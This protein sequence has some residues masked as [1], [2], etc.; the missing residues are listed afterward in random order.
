[1]V[2]TQWL[3]TDM[4][5][6]TLTVLR[7]PKRSPSATFAARQMDPRAAD[8]ATLAALRGGDEAAAFAQVPADREA[9]FAALSEIVS[10]EMIPALRAVDCARFGEAVHQ[11]NRLAGE[12]FAPAQGGPYACPITADI[13]AFLR[14][15]GICG[16]GQS[17]WGPTVFAVIEDE[18]HAIDAV[19]RLGEGRL[20]RVRQA[21]QIRGSVGLAPKFA[22]HYEPL[23]FEGR[24]MLPYPCRRHR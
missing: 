6:V 22:M 16:V 9:R 17:S 19:E 12:P 5:W 3:S 13:I 10:V 23:R 14:L 18:S 11:F 24:Q 20:A 15:S 1:M 4:W 21:E 7:S 2:A 8:L